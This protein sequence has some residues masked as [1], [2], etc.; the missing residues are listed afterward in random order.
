MG[1]AK[2]APEA[3]A[4][5]FRTALLLAIAEGAPSPAVARSRA[6]L[7]T[8]RSAAGLS[9]EEAERARV[10]TFAA[11]LVERGEAP[12]LSPRYPDDPLP[13][14]DDDGEPQARERESG[15]ASGARGP[16]VP[17]PR[18]LPGDKVRRGGKR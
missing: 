13:V 16:R 6:T 11:V 8:W 15:E 2:T 5:L 14:E 9:F 1:P 10:E 7:S 4:G 12:G 3:Y 18:P 17:R